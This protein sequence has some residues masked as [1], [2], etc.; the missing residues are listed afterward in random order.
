[1]TGPAGHRA[2]LVEGE[3]RAPE[4]LSGH[5][6]TCAAHPKDSGLLRGWVLDRRSDQ[7][8]CDDVQGGGFSLAATNSLG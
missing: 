1:V 2:E 4:V 3:A 6:H 8:K 5:L 7:G